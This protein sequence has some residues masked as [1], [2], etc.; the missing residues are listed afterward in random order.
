M[1]DEVEIE[2]VQ[3]ISSKRAS[4][5]SG[6]AQD[7]IGQL[8]RG[9]YID[10]KRIGG[11]WHVSLA[12][13]NEHEK[14]AEIAKSQQQSAPLRFRNS[15]PDID[16]LV[17][18]DGTDYVSASRASQITGYHQD[19][20]GQLARSGSISS[21][22]VGN[23]WYV[24]REAIVAHKLEKD[25]LLGAVQSASA[26]I[27]LATSNF[28]RVPEAS[29]SHYGG[30]YFKYTTDERNLQPEMLKGSRH[31]A[32]DGEP[33]ITETQEALSSPVYINK[34]SFTATRKMAHNV[35]NKSPIKHRFRMPYGI[36]AGAI[37]LTLLSITALSAVYGLKQDGDDSSTLTAN[38]VN[39]LGHAIVYLEKIAVPQIDYFRN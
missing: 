20:V 31:D 9:G 10:A 24:A 17:T 8:A 12:S 33:F 13:V 32:S 34:G 22:Q 23:R 27:N 11:L 28:K 29:F 16:S 7:Y 1:T 30:D 6:Y 4:E 5:L 15:I 37:L 38:V 3:Y 35:E 19:Y 39:A 21:R 25:R 18:F 26:G 36:T 14:K 2:G